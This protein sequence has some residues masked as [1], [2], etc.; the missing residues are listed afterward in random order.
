M[1]L[2]GIIIREQQEACVVRN[3]ET[4]LDISQYPAGT[5]VRLR[6]DPGRIGE[7]SGRKRTGNGF[8]LLEVIF[9]PNDRQYLRANMLELV[10]P[11]ESMW[12]LFKD[13]R[14]GK[15][16]DLSKII[17]TEKLKG[18]LTNVFY[19]MEIGNTEFLPH[20]FKPVLKFIESQR[21]RLLI[22]DE[23]GL[24]KT[25][26]SIY[27]WKELQAREASRRCL[28]VC[29]AMLREK[30]ARDFQIRFN[31]EATIVDAAGLLE[32]IESIKRNP[33]S[34]SIVLITSLEGIRSRD[35]TWDIDSNNYRSRLGGVLEEMAESSAD[36]YY[37]KLFDLVIIDEAH[38]LR[39]AS[40]ASHQTARLLRDNAENMVLLSATPIQT[41]DENLYNLL[42]LISP[43]DY[44]NYFIFNE[45]NNQNSKLIRLESLIKYNSDIAEAKNVLNEITEM[46]PAPIDEYLIREIKEKLSQNTL[47]YEERIDLAKKISERSFYSRFI[48]RT[49]KRDVI[50]NRVIRHPYTFKFTFSDEEL[51]I[52]NYVTEKLR[53]MYCENDKI[54]NFALIARQRQ[55]TS[56]LP[57][58]FKHWS[59]HQNENG[60]KELLWDNFTDL[61]LLDFEQF[62]NVIDFSD[63]LPEERIEY[64]ENIDSKYKELKQQLSALFMKNQAEKVV[65]FSFYRETINY[66][67]RRLRNDNFSA[68]AIYGGMSSEEK[69]KI[70]DYFSGKEGPN[71]LI[72]SEV[73]SEGIDLQ[74]CHIIINYDLPW[75]PMRLE[76]RIGRIDRIGQKSD[77]IYI[78]NI[79]CNDTIEDK[80]LLKL[81][82]RIR[83][84]EESIGDLEDILGDSIDTLALDLINPEL[85]DADRERRMEQ[86]AL[87]IIEKRKIRNELEQRAIDMFGFSDYILRSISEAHE[88]NRYV[89]T[90][91]MIQL[92][93]DFFSSNYPGTI[94]IPYKN[95]DYDL[96]KSARKIKLSPQ[97]KEALGTYIEKNNPQVMTCLHRAE[98]EILCIFDSR[99]K[100]PRGVLSYERIDAIHPLIQWIVSENEKNYQKKHP[101][102]A[103]M[104]PEPLQGIPTGAYAYYVQLWSAKG[105][106]TKNILRFFA[107]PIGDGPISLNDAERLVVTAFRTGKFW[108]FWDD[109]VQI[110]LASRAL[111]E[112]S[113]YAFSL[114]SVFEDEFHAENRQICEQQLS[115]AKLSAERKISDIQNLIDRLKSQNKLKT[116]KAHEGRIRKVNELLEIQK[117]R[118][119]NH[120]NVMSNAIEIALGIIHNGVV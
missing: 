16:S 13:R 52:Y 89:S 38:Y 62:E 67:Y 50:E 101:C 34:K 71:I 3:I 8:L 47:S 87:A 92:V 104:I 103:I 17:I 49:R 22:A 81:Y 118:I 115:Y 14:F 36:S 33:M 32:Q 18:Y 72:S 23:V 46:N 25:I 65:I 80:V 43:E 119:A 95:R 64:L 111:E 4:P 100:C 68:V 7:L 53:M 15:P 98:N 91:D 63:L 41:S 39:N 24:G 86:N 88:L 109:S 45:L 96:T 82:D 5:K 51:E 19:S 114:F 21:G 26:E 85:S 84:F 90:S 70:I 76:Q 116:I 108:A 61:D 78:Y 113:N 59:L 35:E 77:I 94:V 30:W 75:N 83:I 102:S 69:Y 27:I 20:Q 93:D 44:Q 12:D 79:T 1:K 110:E 58:A 66:L 106:K 54:R 56:S 42:T 29:P 74:F 99:E 31:I 97:A 120:Q 117:A 11:H 73:G 57:A 40:T 48:N 10:P 60:L 112:L 107:A 37:N 2:I 6:N 105:W 9:G 28:V 55:M